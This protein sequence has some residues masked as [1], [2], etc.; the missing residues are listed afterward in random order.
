MIDLVVSS[1]NDNYQYDTKSVKD[2]CTI[3]LKDS[4]YDAISLNIIFSDDS[5]LNRLKLEYFNEDV[6]TDVLAFPIQ[7]DTK[8]EAEIYI[9]YDRAISSSKE[10]NVSLNSELIRLI[11]HGILHLLGY[12]DNNDELKKVMFDKQES[13]VNTCKINI[14]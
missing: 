14:V 5:N 3:V 2:L 7:N 12:R 13:I 8:L 4:S 9:S 6:L 10:F 1:T 11:V